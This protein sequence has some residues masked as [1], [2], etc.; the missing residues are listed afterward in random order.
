M[1]I[2]IEHRDQFSNINDKTIHMSYLAFIKHMAFSGLGGKLDL[3][4]ITRFCG[5]FFDYFEI[6]HEGPNYAFN[7][8]ESIRYN[9]TEKGQ[10]SN[11]IGVAIA[12]FLAKRIYCA[13]YTVNYETAM[14]FKGLPI[15]GRRPD[16][17]CFSAVNKKQFSLEAKG[18]SQKTICPYQMDKYK[19]QS[20]TGGLDCNFSVASVAYNL[21]NR[22]KVYF[23]DPIISQ[24]NYSSNLNNSLI[25]EY[26]NNLI[27]ILNILKLKENIVYTLPYSIREDFVAFK[28]FN[29]ENTSSNY[30]N[31]FTKTSCRNPL[32]EQVY[33]HLCIIV[34]KD[35]LNSN[36]KTPPFINLSNF[37]SYYG[38][39]YYKDYYDNDNNFHKDYYYNDNNFH[40]DYYD[41]NFHDD[42]YYKKNYYN[43]NYYID[44]DGIGVGLFI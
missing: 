4:K 2:F 40:N 19:E 9:T 12:D 10:I 25:L 7:L 22:V 15:K 3:Y 29:P 23:Y 20:K 6:F 37:S 43:D 42:N 11:K 32:F 34:H 14:N 16:L 31:I 35:I 39:Y 5:S 44:N 36:I 27:S 41:N 38:H 30:T 8:P 26:Y 18:F 33:K 24:I 13:S 17:Y 1:R 28:I 21:Y